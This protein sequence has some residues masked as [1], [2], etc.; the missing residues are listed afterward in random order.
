MA[1]KT[2]EQMKKAAKNLRAAIG[3]LTEAQTFDLTAE[4]K[5]YLKQ[6]INKID[7]MI[8]ELEGAE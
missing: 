4:Q 3:A 6:L 7:A 2:A 8:Y 1:N 5:D